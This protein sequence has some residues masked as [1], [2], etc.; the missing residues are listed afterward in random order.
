MRAQARKAGG[1]SGQR[2]KRV[3]AGGEGLIPG[4]W[5]LA[6]TVHHQFSDDPFEK[7]LAPIR[8]W[9]TKWEPCSAHGWR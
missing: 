6:L 9:P 3:H 2:E 4:L 8:P 7:A 5:E 1:V